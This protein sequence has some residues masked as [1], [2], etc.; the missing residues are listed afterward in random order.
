MM[1]NTENTKSDELRKV[2]ERLA[3]CEQFVETLNQVVV[4]QQNR[5]QWLE[6]Q[7]TRL[8][9]EVKRLRSLADPL[10]ENEKP[11]HY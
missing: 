2:E 8:I 11:P 4:E 7:N 1:E 5:L 6:L 3:Y 9:E 10:P